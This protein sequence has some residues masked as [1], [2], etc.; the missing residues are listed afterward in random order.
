MENIKLIKVLYENTK[1]KKYN[2]INRQGG[3]IE[4]KLILK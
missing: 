3:D 4:C 2:I 1:N